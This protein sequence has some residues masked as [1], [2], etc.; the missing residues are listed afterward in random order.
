MTRR[1]WVVAIVTVVLIAALIVLYS[2]GL[3][4]N[5]PVAAPAPAS[6]WL[7]SGASR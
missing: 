1:R 4:G 2:L 6:R 7:S 3:L 5:T